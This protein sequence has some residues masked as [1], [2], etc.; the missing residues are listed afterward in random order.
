MLTLTGTIQRTNTGMI[1]YLM[2]SCIMLVCLL[3]T[4]L[5]YAKD[6]SFTWSA[7]PEPVEG[8]RLYYKIDGAASPP[9][10]GTGA[11]EGPSPINVGKKT[12]FTITGLKDNTSY[13]FALTAYNG[14]EESDFSSIVSV[15]APVS[16]LA[17]VIKTSG[18]AGE[19]PFT[20]TFDASASTGQ[21]SNYS[22]NFGDSYASTD[23]ISSHTYQ[24]PGIY[25]A[26]LTVQDGSGL[27]Q[28]ASVDIK[29]TDPVVPPPVL[30]NPTAVVSSS[31]TV[32]VAPLTVQFDGSGSTTA[33]P[34]IVS[35]YW[36]FGDGAVA[37]GSTATHIYVTPGTYQAG[38][39]IIDNAGLSAQTNVPISVSAPPEPK[40][41][42]P[43][44]SFTIK[45]VSVNSQ[46]AIV[47]FDG[48]GSRDPDGSIIEYQWGFGD[49][50]SDYGISVQHAFTASATYTVTLKV[51]D[52]KG[53]TATSSQNYKVVLVKVRPVKK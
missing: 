29:V 5:V 53:G 18:Q 12:A 4:T 2:S 14:F 43:L 19:A 36:N 10:D 41:L 40:N 6:F 11:L 17:A 22:W 8:Y 21:I 1:R 26:T 25:K 35:S 30:T 20:V 38:F 24:F 13:Y 7:N 47:V 39:T 46:Q 34:P 9:F 44:S 31:S 23:A 16:E 49:G 32:G 50:S 48:S 52:N 28:Q 33:Q 37:G 3:V 45:L 42:L 27:S 51:T 15:I